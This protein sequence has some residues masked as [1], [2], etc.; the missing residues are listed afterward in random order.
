M[1]I[2]WSFLWNSFK[3]RLYIT[4]VWV[5]HDFAT[6]SCC[7]LDIQGSYPNLACDTSS[8][9]GDHIC[10]IVLKSDFKSRSYGPSYGH[11][12]GTYGLTDTRAVGEQNLSKMVPRRP[13]RLVWSR[14]H[15]SE[16][17]YLFLQKSKSRND[18]MLILWLEKHNYVK[19]IWKD[20]KCLKTA[21]NL[22]L[23]QGQN[24]IYPQ[25]KW[26]F[27]KIPGLCRVFFIT[28]KRIYFIMQ[29]LRFLGHFIFFP[30]LMLWRP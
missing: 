29:I 20:V 26:R 1:S 14:K 22:F 13:A 4:N 10:E 5:G 12:F 2:W 6:R 24:I 16:S 7:D 19:V 25:F 27:G 18:K 30:F 3:I 15:G 11:E 21:V 23:S 17:V 9:Y 28:S 8:H